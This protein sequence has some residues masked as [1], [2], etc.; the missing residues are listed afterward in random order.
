MVGGWFASNALGR[1]GLVVSPCCQ[2][3]SLRRRR[4]NFDLRV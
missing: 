3:S 4:G 1:M 2:S